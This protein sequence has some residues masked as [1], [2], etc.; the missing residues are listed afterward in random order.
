MSR[1]QGVESNEKRKEKNEESMSEQIGMSTGA[2]EGNS[3]SLVIGFINKNPVALYMTVKRAFPFTMK[4]VVATFRRQGLFINDHVYDFAEFIS[5]AAA[6]FH[7]FVLLSERLCVNRVKHRLIVFGLLVRIIPF[8]VFP[9]LI[10]R[11]EP[12][13]RNFPAR[14][15]HTFL[16]GGDSLGIVTRISG[17]RIAVFGTQW[18]FVLKIKPV[19]SGYSCRSKG[20]NGPSFRYF[21]GNVNGQPVA[22]RYV[23]GLCNA[24]K[25]NIA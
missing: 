17:F 6:F 7:Q 23:Y 8:K 24:H 18:T 16:N 10:K 22:G 11:M 1:E 9:H 21:V 19:V 2:M 5:I 4:R 20:K 14:N 3:A 15:S 12:L 13:S 25:L